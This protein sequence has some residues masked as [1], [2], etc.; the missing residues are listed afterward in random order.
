MI[1]QERTT[2]YSICPTLSSCFVFLPFFLLPLFASFLGRYSISSKK[3]L[4]LLRHDWL[5]ALRELHQK[6]NDGGT[7]IRAPVRLRDDAKKKRKRHGNELTFS[8][9]P[10]GRTEVTPP[11]VPGEGYGSVNEAVRGEIDGK[12]GF[13]S[14]SLPFVK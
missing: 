12:I 3:P 13:A 1:E 8:H 10:H 4:L 7:S 2:Y 14:I 11:P 6:S 9:P 5:E